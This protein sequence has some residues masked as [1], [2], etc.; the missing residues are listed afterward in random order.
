MPTSITTTPEL[1]LLERGA[2]RV[3]VVLRPFSFT[4]RRAGRRLVRAAGVWVADGDV[5]DTFVQFTE[6][7]IPQEELSPRERALRGEVEADEPD[8]NPWP[9]ARVELNLTPTSGYLAGARLPA[10]T[11]PWVSNPALESG[12]S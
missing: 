4:V 2:I 8:A 10:V 1:L 12:D 5:H 7:V 3:E 9:T 6:G 11:Q